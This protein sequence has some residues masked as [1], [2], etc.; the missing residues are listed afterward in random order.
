MGLSVR[1]LEAGVVKPCRLRQL[2][3][4]RNHRRGDVH[5]HRAAAH[6]EARRVTRL[7]GSASDV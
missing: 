3:G 2:A 5:P 7:P 1:L 6:G 4:P